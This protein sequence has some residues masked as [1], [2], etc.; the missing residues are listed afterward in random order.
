MFWNNGGTPLGSARLPAR[1]NETRRLGLYS[2]GGAKEGP[3]R[4]PKADKICEPKENTDSGEVGLTGCSIT[5]AGRAGPRLV[6]LPGLLTEDLKK[7]GC[8]FLFIYW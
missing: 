3:G 2:L 4:A 8:S 6:I 1:W 7:T 5:D